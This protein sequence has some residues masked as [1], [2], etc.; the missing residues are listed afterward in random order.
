[1][2]KDCQDI[3]VVNFDQFKNIVINLIQ[4]DNYKDLIEDWDKQ[5][6]YEKFEE[7]PGFDKDEKWFTAFICYAV[8]YYTEEKYAMKVY[9]FFYGTKGSC[10]LLV[11]DTILPREALKAICKLEDKVKR[12]PDRFFSSCFE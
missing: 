12:N 6:I 11:T 5:I 4:K 3:G 1:M 2:I 8:E 10:Q 7:K 9:D